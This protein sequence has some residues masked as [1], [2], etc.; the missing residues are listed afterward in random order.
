MNPYDDFERMKK[1]DAFAEDSD[2]ELDDDMYCDLD[3]TKICDNCFKCLETDSDYASI[4][5]DGVYMDG[6][7]LY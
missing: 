2:E 5:I 1:E 3:P 6:E 7:R 4:E